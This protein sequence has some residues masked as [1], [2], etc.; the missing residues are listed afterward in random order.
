MRQR[1]SDHA[2]P[3]SPAIQNL[4]VVD[5]LPADAGDVWE[6]RPLIVHACYRTPG[7]GHVILRGVRAGKPYEQMLAVTLPAEAPGHAAIASMWARAK[8]DALRCRRDASRRRSATRW[9][10][11]RSRTGC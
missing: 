11:S 1:G 4:D 7:Q 9:S 6:Q 10:A 3:G 5:V 8:V 2:H